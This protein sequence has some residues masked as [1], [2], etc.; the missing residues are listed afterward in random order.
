MIDMPFRIIDALHSIPSV[1][2]AISILLLSSSLF[3]SGCATTQTICNPECQAQERRQD[4]VL[5]NPK[6][7]AKHKKAILIGQVTLGM[8]KKDVIAALGHPTT[9]VD[10]NAFW[11]EREQWIYQLPGK[12]TFYYFKF[13]RLHSWNTV[14]NA[15]KKSQTPSL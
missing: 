6:L 8:S 12:T 10:T 7:L 15:N 13:G 3:L 5:A 4:Y 9:T 2:K 11:A 14:A 1:Q